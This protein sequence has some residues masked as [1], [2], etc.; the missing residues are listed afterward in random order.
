MEPLLLT[1]KE[2]DELEMV[3]EAHSS[4]LKHLKEIRKQA[5]LEFGCENIFSE[6]EAQDVVVGVSI[7][8]FD[9][10]HIMLSNP[11]LSKCHM[12]CKSFSIF[13]LYFLCRHVKY[14]G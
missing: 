5:E 7:A 10:G 1:S 6:T 13:C 12:S 3:A 2:E 8:R 9:S 11:K 4:F 14:S